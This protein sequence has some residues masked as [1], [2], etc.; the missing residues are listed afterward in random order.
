M[1]TTDAEIKLR[2]AVAAAITEYLTADQRKVS[3]LAKL[4]RAHM[5]ASEGYLEARIE[6]EKRR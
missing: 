4:G 5:V 3:K 1:K 2:A 6:F